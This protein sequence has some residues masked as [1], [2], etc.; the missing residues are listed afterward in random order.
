MERY[1]KIP[2]D[3]LE[4][5]S[6]IPLNVYSILVALKIRFLL[7]LSSRFLDGIPISTYR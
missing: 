4:K 1:S 7:A 3:Y 6:L 5:I 2:R